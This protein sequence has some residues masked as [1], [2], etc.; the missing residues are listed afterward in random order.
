MADRP[1]ILMDDCQGGYLVTR[2]LLDLHHRCI[3]GI[4]KAD[5]FQGRERHKGYV[6]ALQEAGIPY[7]PDLVVWFHTEDRK[8]KPVLAVEQMLRRQIPVDAFVC[9][10]D[11]IAMSVCQELKNLGKRIPEDISVTGYDNSLYA[12]GDLSL[13]TIDHPQEK[14]GEMAAELLLEKIRHVPESQSQ[15]ERLIAPRLIMGN[16]C[17]PR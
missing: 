14:L 6:K 3:A 8:S 7:D 4:F 15:V 13:T 5:D 1:H 11:Q 9:Y 17:R 10:N 16:S 2:Y 12:R